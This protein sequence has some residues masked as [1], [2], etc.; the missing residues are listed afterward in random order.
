MKIY[1]SVKEGLI[2]TV[3]MF[4]IG[5]QSCTTHKPTFKGTALEKHES[6]E[7]SGFDKD[8][9]DK[10]TA[11]INDHS[12]TTGMVVLYD[13]KVLYEYGDTKEISYIA[14]CRK[15]VLSMLYGKHVDNGSIDL[16]QKIGSI[17][18]DEKDGLLPIEK[19]ATINDI[20]TSRSG[21]FHVAANGGYDKKNFL[22]RGSVKPGEYFVYSNWDFNVAG[23]ILEQETGNSIY[24]ELEKQLA[25]PLGFQDWN[26]KNQKK[27]ENKK[28]S[29]YPAYHIYLSTRDMA[30][31]GQLM[32]NE[33]QWNGKQL[34]PSQ[35]IQKTTTTITPT[36]VVNE[37]Y[38]RTDSS[39]IQFSYGYMWWLVDYFKGIP[40]FEG[41]YSATGYGGQYITVIPKRKLVI[42]HKT[43]LDL[44]TRWGLAPGGTP[45]WLYWDI[46]HQL[47]GDKKSEQERN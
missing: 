17:G 42:A 1:K 4:L 13:G 26:L 10:L 40:D 35:W 11:F 39:T 32:L 19:E 21:V 28:K 15:S 41:A 36:E 24:E 23:Y 2:V 30:K 43:K 16:Q 6:L 34:I 44:L 20:I 14:S 25:K 5:F 45:D 3:I 18:I 7:N 27:K 38:N 9:L 12:E 47:V 29:R 8:K 22:E 33:G 31:I 46:L 37:R